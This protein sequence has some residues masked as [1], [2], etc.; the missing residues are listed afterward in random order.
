VSIY[1]KLLWCCVMEKSSQWVDPFLLC[2]APWSHDAEVSPTR[3]KAPVSASL[4][5]RFAWVEKQAFELLRAYTMG[6]LIC[7]AWKKRLLL[8]TFCSLRYAM[9]SMAD[10]TSSDASFH[11]WFRA[12]FQISRPVRDHE[13][14]QTHRDFLRWATNATCVSQGP[15]TLFRP[16]QYRWDLQHGAN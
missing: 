13:V 11:P 7:S 14:S 6:I 8:R 5:L 12:A 15:P 9:W 10:C 2:R 3:E 1:Y 16:P 4:R